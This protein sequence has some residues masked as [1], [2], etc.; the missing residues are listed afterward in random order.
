MVLSLSLIY[1]LFTSSSTDSTSMGQ[2]L[3]RDKHHCLPGNDLVF[4]LVVT[5]FLKVDTLA[6]K[7]GQVKD[8]LF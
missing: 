3:G 2:N 4:V 7:S 6:I 1:L 5:D 8:P